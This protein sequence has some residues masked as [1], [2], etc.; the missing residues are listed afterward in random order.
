MSI[1]TPAA[2]IVNP[3]LE[4]LSGPR[5]PLDLK[6]LY[7]L[8][9]IGRFA[10]TARGDALIFET[11]ISGR[12]NLWRVPSRGGWPLQLTIEEDRTLLEDVSM[13]G[14]FLVYAQDRGGD[15]KPNLFLL[16]P[17]GGTPIPL[18]DTE[19]V[20]YETACFSH[21]GDRIA[22]AA[23]LEAPGAYGIYVV[24]AE[25]RERGGKPVVRNGFPSYLVVPSGGLMWSVG[26]WSRDDSRLA[27]TRTSDGLHN[28]VFV[29]DLEGRVREIVPDDGEH[30]TDIVGWSP[31]GR[32]LL[33]NSNLHPGGQVAP[34]LLSLEDGTIEWLVDSIWESGALDWSPDGRFVAWALNEAGA[35]R[36]Y[37]R[38]LV[39]GQ[40]RPASPGTGCV[41]GAAFSPDGRALAFRFGAAD[42]PVDLWVLERDPRPARVTEAFVGG[43]SADRM[44]R[45]H[46]VTYPGGDGTTIA[47]FLYLPRGAVRGRPG[48]GIVMIRGG[49]TAQSQDRFARNIQYLVSRGYVVIEPNYRGSTGF[50]RAFQEANRM[51]LG[52]GDLE[53]IIAART[54]LAETGYVD[55]GRVA[56]EGGSYGGYLTLMALAKAPDLWAAGIAIVPFANWF[57]E[58]ENEDETLQAFDRMM[59]GDPEANRDLWIDRSPFFFVDRITAPLLIQAGANDIRCPA[60]ETREIAS[61][62]RAAGGTV[63]V[64]I[65]DD[66]GHGFSKRENAID[67]FRQRMV[68]LERYLPVSPP[69]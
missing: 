69:E 18:T 30:L 24:P 10:W 53:D 17:G 12:V 7:H 29:A 23:E 63:E 57:T 55:P 35:E 19:G 46:L 49:P 44:V 68:F 34:G 4:A 14:R 54:F 1:P 33:V 26:G 20:G 9:Y 38:D 51:D 5:E 21:K 2:G 50:G 61:R 28:G 43:L 66:E 58:Y 45:P 65:Y 22:F 47:A 32:R 31:D 3:R 25:E 64:K 60:S 11:D 56:V 37:L 52:G 15:E 62:I 59:M 40:D 27:L 67:A 8:R 41:D 39:T 16:N 48:P 6:S 42:R 13:D 36:L